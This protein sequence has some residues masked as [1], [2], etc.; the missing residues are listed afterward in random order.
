MSRKAIFGAVSVIGS[1]GAAVTPTST[2]D[3]IRIAAGTISIFEDDDNKAVLN[4]GTL[5]FTSAGNVNAIFGAVS[6]I[7]SDGAAVTA[8]STDDCIRIA[9]GTVSIFQDDNNK[10]VVNASGM[11]I[12]Q[13]G[14]AVGKFGA[15]T[16][17]GDTANEHISASSAG[18]TIKDGST[19]VGSFKATGAIIG[20]DSTAHI[21]ASTLDINLIQDS[22]NLSK[23]SAAGMEVTQSGNGV[24]SFGANTI[25]T[26]GTVTLQGTTGTIGDEKLVI[27]NN[28]ISMFSAGAEVFDVTGAV[29]TVGSATDQVEINGTSGITIREN[30]VDTIT[31]ADGVVTVGSSTD[32]VTINGT[33]G[34]T[35]RENNVDSISLTDGVIVVGSSTDKVTI[36]G[37]SGIT[38]KENNKDN[39]SLVDGTIKI[40][41]DENDST[42]VQ[43]DS[44][45]V[46]IIEDV[47]GTN[48]TVATFG[49][50][51]VIGPVANSKSRI[52]LSSGIV[53]IINR[54]GSG[55]DATAIQ[56][57]A[58]GTATFAGT[59]TAG[60]GQ[61][62]NYE[63]TDTQLMSGTLSLNTPVTKVSTVTSMSFDGGS[64]ASF[65]MQI[66]EITGGISTPYDFTDIFHETVMK[67]GFLQSDWQY[68]PDS[69]SGRYSGTTINTGLIS[70]AIKGVQQEWIYNDA[71]DDDFYE[72]ITIQSVSGSVDAGGGGARGASFTYASGSDYNPLVQIG[73]YPDAYTSGN[74]QGISIES[75]SILQM[76]TIGSQFNQDLDAG[77]PGRLR[78]M[79]NGIGDT[80]GRTVGGLFLNQSI[81]A[82]PNPSTNLSTNA[83][84]GIFATAYAGSGED[85]VAILAHGGG[86]GGSGTKYSFYGTDGDFY[87]EDDITTDGNIS[88]SA[89]STGSFGR[90]STDTLDLNSIQGNWTNAGNTVADLGTV[91]T[92]DINGGTIN[93]ITDLAVADGGTGVSTLTNGGVLLGSGTGAITAMAVLTNG[94]MIVGDGTTDPVAESGATLRTSIGVGT[95]D[96]VTFAT[97]NTGQGANELYDMN[98]N[99]TTTSAVTFATVNTGQGANEL[100]D[101]DQNVKSTNSPTFHDLTVTGKLFQGTSDTVY[102][103][104]QMTGGGTVADSTYTT[105][106]YNSEA[107]DE[108][109]DYNNATYKFTAPCNGIYFFSAH[110]LWGNLSDWDS[111]DNPIIAFSVND[112]A[113][114]DGRLLNRTGNFTEFFSMHTTAIIKLDS[115]DTVNVD[116]YQNT[117]DTLDLYNGGGEGS[118]NQF[119]GTLIHSLV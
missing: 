94:Q 71:Y 65:K 28:S 41:V 39:I 66:K 33:S 30:N 93:G 74:Q 117:G 13:G 56:L 91:T 7:G 61:I 95:G 20:D 38:I 49:L 52:E 118:Y 15:I 32:K 36:N 72:K 75:G 18:I 6:V 89:T 115:G 80:H 98:Q 90:T 37:T 22:N 47:S 88:G 44:D 64:G 45:S 35:I 106:P 12:T 50:A 108:G 87:N 51:T 97:V 40:G 113:G 112:A 3:C 109:G 99:V 34:I 5:T 70:A 78:V 10:A 46:D 59:I 26:G 82:S 62:A 110:F 81:F 16:T 116:A 27:E 60:A 54:N 100:Y 9:N 101:M 29:V 19:V 57:A 55:T 103:E 104:A 8:T 21:S 58:D 4:S 83:H 114:S 63:I 48:T 92:I 69:N 73:R 23:L 1:D 17:I 2:D 86:A 76:T 53:K 14:T 67:T 105:V 84:I 31:L 77:V 43:I 96:A 42:F 11:V 79:L 111:G 119:M 68:R 85:S 24:A 25:I 107:N 102:F